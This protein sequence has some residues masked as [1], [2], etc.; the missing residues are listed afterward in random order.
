[1]EIVHLVTQ[2]RGGPVDHAVDMAI[3]MTNLGHS[4]HV[5]GP[6]GEYVA[7]LRDTD[8]A[9]HHVDVRTKTDVRGMRQLAAVMRRIGPDILHCQDRRAGL[10]GRLLARRQD[11]ASIYTLHGVPDP[12]ASTVAGNMAV[13]DGSGRL[14]NQSLLGNRY[15]ETRLGRLRRSMVVVPCRALESYA[16]DYLQIPADQV[17]SVHNGVANPGDYPDLSQASAPARVAWLGLMQP[18][19]RVPDLVHAASLVPGLA[20]TLIG[21]GPERRN[22]EDAVHHHGMES[23]TTFAGFQRDPVAYLAK[24]SLFALISGAEACPM[25]LLK[26]MA[27]G[28]PV[29]ASRV[30]GVP[31]IIRHDIDGLL[32]EPGDIQGIATALRRLTEDAALRTYLGTQA[33]KRIHSEFTA[34]HCALKLIEIYRQVTE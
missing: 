8:V 18:V 19:K 6:Q 29:V 27:C 5:I 14:V 3:E 26:A 10:V 12:L 16:R 7:Q 11:I 20:L 1:M 17:T 13:D 21:D 23:V 9:F 24:S 30:G 2:G 32:V 31:E 22:I 34:T 4:C 33:R 25:A 15:L 28:L